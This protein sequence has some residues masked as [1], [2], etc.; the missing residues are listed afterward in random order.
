MIVKM[1]HINRIRVNNVKYNFGT[2]FYDDFMMRFSCKNT[3]YDLANGGGKS[4][5]M[6]LL[7]QNLI[8]NCTLDD[9]Q[10]IEKLFRTSDGSKTIHSLIE[11][12]LSDVH[13]KDNFKYMLT[14]F[15]ARKAKEK[16]GYEESSQENAED[17]SAGNSQSIEYFNYCIFYR[18]FNDND[19]KNLPL[20]DN[21]ERIT[22][23][24]L[25]NYLRELEKKDLNL[26][27][28]IFDRKGDYQ[29]FIAG[30][31]LYE[32]EWEIIRGINKTEGHV[33]TYFETNYKTTRKV[34]EDL[35]IE[36]IIEKSFRN[37]YLEEASEDKLARTL[38]NIKDKLI[39]LSKKKEEINHYD[40]QM[41]IIDSFIERTNSIRQLYAGMEDSF[42][43]IKKLYNSIIRKEQGF[44]QEKDR[45]F[46]Q[47]EN[48]IHEKK[49]LSRKVETAR[50]I[51]DR[52]ELKKWEQEYEERK[53]RYDDVSGELNAMLNELNLMEGTNDYLEY[54]E[55]KKEYDKQTMVIE[56]L[57]KDNSELLAKLKEAVAVKRLSDEERKNDI[58]RE[59]LREKSKENEEVSAI[60][61]LEEK[62]KQDGNALAVCEYEIR[63]LE[64]EL[65]GL[66]VL[67]LEKK[68]KTSLLL[69]GEAVTE[70][71]KTEVTI[72]KLKETLKANEEQ[73]EVLRAKNIALRIEYER[74]NAKRE[75]LEKRREILQQKSSKL[76][77]SSEKFARIKE[78]YQEKD[79]ERLEK[80]IHMAYRDAILRLN[81]DKRQS[82]WLKRRQEALD[83]NRPIPESE[84]IGKVLDYVKRYHTKLAVS[85]A[86]YI[87]KLEEDDRLSVI[88]RNPIL[89]FSVIVYENAEQLKNDF[90]MWEQLKLKSFVP[91]IDAKEMED[92][93]HAVK[94]TDIIRNEAMLCMVVPPDCF[95]DAIIDKEKEALRKQVELNG[96]SRMRKSENEEVIFEDYI[97]IR[98]INENMLEEADIHPRRALKE[99]EAELKN[100]NEKSEALK[101]EL[102]GN[103]KEEEN[104]TEKIELLTKEKEEWESQSEI[105]KSISQTLEAYKK[106]EKAKNQKETKVNA[107]RR[108]LNDET[109]RLAALKNMHA[110][111]VERI[112]QRQQEM[113]RLEEEW[114][115][116]Y[117]TYYDET[118]Y[119]TVAE[120]NK[121]KTI[122]EIKNIVVGKEEI[123]V[124]LEALL[125]SVLH[126]NGSVA[127]KE[128]LL[129]HYQAAMQR[130][131]GRLDYLGYAKSMF[132]ELYAKRELM[133]VS[134]PMMLE[135]RKMAEEYRKKKARARALMDEGRTDRDKLQGKI[136]H[137]ISLIEKTYG[138]FEESL[139]GSEEIDTFIHENDRILEDLNERYAVLEKSIKEL[140]ESE[141]IVS[142]LK[143]NCERSMEKSGL[144]KDG[145][146]GFFEKTKAK[147]LEEEYHIASADIDRFIQDR[148][149]RAEEFERE[150]TMLTDT[151]KKSGADR[152]ADELRANISMPASALAVEQLVSALKEINSLI[153]LEKQRVEK[154]ITDIQVIKDNFENQ[155]LQSCINI[156]TELERL[157]RLSRITIDDENIAMLQLKVPYISEEL[158]KDRMSEYIDRIA[159]YT[160]TF[161]NQEDRL[162]YIKNNL[163]WKKIF[164]VIVTDMN[165]IRLNLYKRE[166]ISGQ[167]RYLP[168]EEAVG[169]TGQSQGIYI[170]FLISIINYISSIHAKD[171]LAVG[172]R[173]VIFI[174]NPFGAAKDLYIWE[175]I[176]KLLKTNNVQ[177]I[178]PARGVTP[179]I[180]GRFDV[181][182]VLGQRMCN[183]KQQ[184]V[185]VDYHSDVVTEELEY[186]SLTYEQTSL[187]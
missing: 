88:R 4:V 2:Q 73:R 9:K 32:S 29:R 67:M 125:T 20:S 26:K 39:E 24:G 184:T 38:L 119:Q 44:G 168:Y 138:A 31:G 165:A 124:A 21:G 5:L 144:K 113:E 139:V 86:A 63:K 83:E 22:Y 105:L 59:L 47:R 137:A 27:V 159:G 141:V 170:Q 177:L 185:V 133:A 102:T 103:T 8:P 152:L 56:S 51:L 95:K 92:F 79:A 61:K 91:I 130:S 35:L 71:G 179:A 98:L 76:L 64:S 149:K 1:P 148:Y 182:Y 78:V 70:L 40:R 112:R 81:E 80:K 176:F 66:N 85:G 157:S 50:I 162:R 77:N 107:L 181:N 11:W 36:E 127:D 90:A 143:K 101:V 60:E 6:L 186:T 142:L 46:L 121:G 123:E 41:E 3:I 18:S 172:L 175:P 58:R 180:T 42:W 126:E 53:N 19:I 146:A 62:I 183:G 14:G 187:F 25:K 89:A 7:F 16:T 45:L 132:D 17:L 160:D 99:L 106:S 122:R 167:S 30:Y 128:E 140:E 55:A 15:C 171:A 94:N 108:E 23:T 153:A 34:V 114:K 28:R 33:R 134:A 166:R 93:H 173:K 54:V 156:K 155:C 13:V 116:K 150:L 49:N 12:R 65:E 154:G 97:F 163:C 161:D 87:G 120:C 147:E 158:Y 74:G 109:K 37:R 118:I 169:S 151:L 110:G 43:R 131:L 84:D 96:Q 75:A 69:P 136:N 100:E 52:R 10:P 72:A 82:E 145:E 117:L 115:E 68:S 48:I 111:R 178:V 135:K 104:I 174:D 129:N 57:M 164:S